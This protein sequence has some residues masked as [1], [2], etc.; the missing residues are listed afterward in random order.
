[1]EEWKNLLKE[2]GR[3]MNASKYI[4]LRRCL[5]CWQVN[6]ID[7]KHC[8]ECGYWLYD[9]ATPI[10]KEEAIKKYEKLK[11]KHDFSVPQ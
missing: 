2:L 10:E 5:Q 4:L 9:E 3:E 1:M 6:D 7:N 11:E 8:S